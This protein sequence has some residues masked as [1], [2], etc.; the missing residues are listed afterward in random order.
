[1][2]Q[3]LAAQRAA[4][5]SPGRGRVYHPW[6]E[7]AV[8]WASLAAVVLLVGVPMAALLWGTF[9][10]RSPVL[11]G[12][13]LTL[14]NW[15]DTYTSPVLWGSLLNTV[16]LAVPVTAVAVAAGALFSWLLTSTDVPWR[17]QLE[18]LVLAPF[19]LSP[20]VGAIAWT[21][22]A[23]PRTGF[24]NL[25]LGEGF[26]NIYSFGGIV[27]VMSLYYVPYA[28]LLTAGAIRSMDASLL[29][30]SRMCGGSLWATLRRV[31][32]PLVA[33]ALAAAASL[34]FILSAEMFSIP[35]LL[36]THF[37]FTN[38][39]Y[40]I[41]YSV[42]KWPP[43]WP[44][45]ATM[46]TVL[47]WIVGLGVYWNQWLTRRS[48]RYV[49]ISGKG[50]RTALVR[51]GRL[52]W[53]GLALCLLYVALAVVLPYG[54]L[55]VSSFMKYSSATFTPD[56][57][58]LANYSFFREES[59]RR[60]LF[61]TLALAVLT[62]TVVALLGLLVGYAVQRTGLALR[63]VV[64]Y[65]ASLPLAVPGVV[66]GVGLLWAYVKVPLPI[67]GTLLIMLLAYVAKELPQGVRVV[68]STIVQVDRELEEASR[69]CGGG[70]WGTLRRVTLPLLRPALAYV[71]IL[72]FIVVSRE[73]SAA[74]MLYGPRSTVL[75]VLLWDLMESGSVQRA[76]ALAVFQT[77]LI[78]VGLFTA[79]YV[80]R[81]RLG[82]AQ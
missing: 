5:P 7:R 3:D 14:A 34:I 50:H 65:G 43:D 56:L 8:V 58:T 53:V 45:A 62:P 69:V 37:G 20:F 46:G 48:R 16:A 71:W 26:V 32:V 54:A 49:T 38:L 77:A 51:L 36:G 12:G 28:Y 67:Y 82:P 81:V 63:R 73:I 4:W 41:Y 35:G 22:L 39:P 57:W 25:W 64:D 79:R 40:E 10:T 31:T 33:P 78:L 52:R 68:T 27:W 80:L 13:R 59:F 6:P 70:L 15:A 17:S 76:Y 29:E 24:L 21:S 61:N 18:T 23:A 66:F 42:R 72:V 11:P 19:F 1:M 74:I 75:S 60:A 44:K 9:Q 55:L 47:F 2:S 30:A